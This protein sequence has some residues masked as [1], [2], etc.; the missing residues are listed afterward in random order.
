[1]SKSHDQHEAEL[2]VL[3]QQ[4]QQAVHLASVHEARVA[5][6][7]ADVEAANKRRDSLDDSMDKIDQLNEV[8]SRQHTSTLDV[9][10]LQL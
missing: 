8:F 1:M 5:Q 3:E 2:E 7:K 6:L 10:L 9:V 4:L